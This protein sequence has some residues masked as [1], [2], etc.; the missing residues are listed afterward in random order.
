MRSILWSWPSR[1]LFFSG[2][3]KSHG[4]SCRI[5]LCGKGKFIMCLL[6]KLVGI[7]GMDVV[8]LAVGVCQMVSQPIVSP[9]PGILKAFQPGKESDGKY[10][11]KSA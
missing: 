9:S 6:V 4:V 10:A 3:R 8:I 11:L 1:Q 5:A 7:G 2:K